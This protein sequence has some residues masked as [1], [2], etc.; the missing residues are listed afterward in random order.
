MLTPNE[1]L[2]ILVAL[3]GLFIFVWLVSD[4]DDSGK[5]FL[6]VLLALLSFIIMGIIYFDDNIWRFAVIYFLAM[7]LF[8]GLFAN[9]LANQQ[10]K[11]E[12]GTEEAEPDKDP[13]REPLVLEITAV[14]V[15]APRV[16]TRRILCP[17]CGAPNQVFDRSMTDC[18]YC[19]S[20]L[21]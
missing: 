10:N 16:P 4:N 12:T 9:R 2:I 8:I 6:E 17:H 13:V 1:V 21:I 5:G 14:A 19:G 20:S 11:A 18:A 15:D 7:V 3:H